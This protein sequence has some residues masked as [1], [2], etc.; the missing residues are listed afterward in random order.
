MVGTDLDKVTANW[1][2][3]QA[4]ERKNSP[5]RVVLEVKGGGKGVSKSSLNEIYSRERINRRLN[6]VAL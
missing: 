1:D 5:Y 6:Y 4:G 3:E 2:H